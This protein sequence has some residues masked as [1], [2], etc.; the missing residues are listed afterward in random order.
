MMMENGAMI[1]PM[2]AW[3]TLRGKCGPE[4]LHFAGEGERGSKEYCTI[5]T[6][7]EMVSCR[8]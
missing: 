5:R 6:A 2:G 1:V 4:G 3:H 8:A 7:L